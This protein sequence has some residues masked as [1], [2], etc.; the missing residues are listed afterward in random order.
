MRS[1]TR[2]G[3]SVA[4]D[5]TVCGTKAASAKDCRLAPSARKKLSSYVADMSLFFE[6]AV[7][8][9]SVAMVHHYAKEVPKFRSVVR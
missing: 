4:V 8:G 3:E 5:K 1:A 9:M 2:Y 6:A 7:L